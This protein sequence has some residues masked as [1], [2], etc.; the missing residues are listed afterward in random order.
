M[1]KLEDNSNY[2]ILVFQDGAKQLENL[3]TPTNMWG[4][5]KGFMNWRKAGSPC[6]IVKNNVL[7]RK[8][9]DVAKKLRKNDG[10]H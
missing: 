6:Q 9:K 7:Y 4:T 2:L 1:F 8:A 3:E 5:I 10:D